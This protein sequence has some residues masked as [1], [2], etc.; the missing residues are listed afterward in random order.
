MLEKEMKMQGKKGW[1]KRRNAFTSF[2]IRNLF[3]PAARLIWGK[4]DLRGVNEI[5]VHNIHKDKVN[6]ST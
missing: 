2:C 6:C 5:E 1:G 4:M 3:R